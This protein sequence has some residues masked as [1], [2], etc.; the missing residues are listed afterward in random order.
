MDGVNAG[1]LGA[2]ID[3]DST[4]EEALAAMLRDD[5]PMV[6]VKDGGASSSAC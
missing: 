5:R 2:A 6:G 4:L 1:E 3:L